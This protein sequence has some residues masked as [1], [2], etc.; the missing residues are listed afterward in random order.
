ME[1]LQDI[2]LWRT[3]IST[4]RLEP[5]PQKREDI[6]SLLKHL[7]NIIES[8]PA[9]VALTAIRFLLLEFPRFHFVHVNNFLLFFNERLRVLEEKV[10]NA[11]TRMLVSEDTF[12][13]LFEFIEDW[14]LRSDFEGFNEDMG[15][16]VLIDEFVEQCVL[17]EAVVRAL[18]D[19]YSQFFNKN[20][21]QIVSSYVGTVSPLSVASANPRFRASLSSDMVRLKLGS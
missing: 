17:A 16:P 6:R 5:P 12:S 2:L 20:L 11:K 8:L 21:L 4:L 1:A 19:G 14:G 7:Y 3:L 9:P 10:T 13:Y 15:Y 18:Q